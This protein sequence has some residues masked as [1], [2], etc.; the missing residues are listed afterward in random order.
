MN[1]TYF[2]TT[3]A[4]DLAGLNG[5]GLEQCAKE[6][7]KHVEEAFYNGEIIFEGDGAMKWESNGHYLPE[8]CAEAIAFIRNDANTTTEQYKLIL[9]ASVEATKEKRD[10]QNDEFIAEYRERN[11]NRVLSA[12]EQYEMR[13]AFGA[14]EKVVDCIT[15]QVFQ[16]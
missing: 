5:K 9:N 12:E 4:R 13:A 7:V 10:K 1:T 14:G 15:G 8:E 16:L 3:F 6:T 2:H 11:K